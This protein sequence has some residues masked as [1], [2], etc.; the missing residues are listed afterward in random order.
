MDSLAKAREATATGGHQK[1]VAANRDRGREE[2]GRRGFG[3]IGTSW[4]Q[5]EGEGE[6]SGER[7]VNRMEVS[8]DLGK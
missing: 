1:G 4:R 8:R 6:V 7:E 5:G 3:N 2:R